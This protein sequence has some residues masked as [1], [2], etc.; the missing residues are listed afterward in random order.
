MELKIVVN[1]ATGFEDDKQA[2]RFA[3]ERLLEREYITPEYIEACINRESNF[4]T[5]LLMENGNNIAIPHSDYNLVKENSISIVRFDK[6][7]KFGQMDDPDL[8]VECKALF[9]LAFA[10][11]DQHMSM[12]RKLFTLFQ[13][14]EFSN[15]CLTLDPEKTIEYINT[16]LFG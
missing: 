9:N 15:S 10:T 2:I 12:L 5:G 7:I 16:K 6:P 11:T 3:G 4:P 13:E 1:D 14:D 8:A